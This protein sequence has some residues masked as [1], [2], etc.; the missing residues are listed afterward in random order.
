MKQ[1]D[2][3]NKKHVQEQRKQW[4]LANPEYTKQYQINNRDRK[5]KYQK[6]KRKTDPEY[7]LKSN[8]K[9]R[10]HHALNSQN[11]LKSSH[12]MD[13]IGC[14]IE[15]LKEHLEKQFKPGMSW[16]DRSSFH[17]D[18]IRPCDDFNL[19]DEEEQKKCFHYS[20]LRPL[21]PIENL[22]KSNKVIE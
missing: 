15:F 3:D 19:L 10:L 8:L 5:N 16:Q 21:T 13:L 20:N 22:Q 12:T 9:S 1:W 11:V 6:D 4:V 2:L 18:H 17:I 14:S 7:N